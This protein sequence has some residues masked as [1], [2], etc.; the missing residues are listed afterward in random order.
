MEALGTACTPSRGSHFGLLLRWGMKSSDTATDSSPL[1]LGTP[2]E[3]PDEP[4]DDPPV[5]GIVALR[6]ELGRAPAMARAL[7]AEL[8]F[9]AIAVGRG[10]EP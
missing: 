4:P 6:E 7:I 2:D 1:A 10:G 9:R 5:A 8:G 3:P